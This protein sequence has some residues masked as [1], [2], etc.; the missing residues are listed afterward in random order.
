MGVGLKLSTISYNKRM[1]EP[2]KTLGQNFLIDERVVNEMVTALEVNQD[3]D[4]I[5]IG[6]GH[7]I[8]TEVLARKIRDGSSQLFAVEID[9]RFCRKL[10]EMF[11]EDRNVKIIC[12]DA[13]EYLPTFVP[14]RKFKILGSLPY[15]ITSPILHKII[16]M[17]TLPEACVLLMQKEVAEKVGNKAPD[18]SYISSFVQTFFSVYYLGKVEAKKFNPVPDVDGGII[19][20]DKKPVSLS[21]EFIEKYEGFLHRAFSHPRKMLNKAFSKEELEKGD[22]NPDLRAQNLDSAEWLRF[23]R[24]LNPGTV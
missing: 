6:P 18:S 13:L 7:G 22:I 24:L 8:L 10:D 21:S 4:F 1:F 15:Y 11:L 2:I 14:E 17:K 12:E 19:K 20:L 3:E 9:E 16:K 5:E 23:F